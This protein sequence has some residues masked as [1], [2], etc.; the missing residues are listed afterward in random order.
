MTD[1]NQ[2]QQDPN[3]P[4]AP[5][6][7]PTT[8]KGTKYRARTNLSLGGGLYVSA[9]EI[10]QTTDGAVAEML[11]KRG[12]ISTDL[13]GGPSDPSRSTQDKTATDLMADHEKR[14]NENQDN[15]VKP[16][17]GGEPLPGIIPN[18]R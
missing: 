12:A 6:P 17:P 16:K 13:R 15:G 5:A 1:Q 8:G 2:Q 14:V 4:A 10:F 7:A 3:K 11:L 9:G 18:N